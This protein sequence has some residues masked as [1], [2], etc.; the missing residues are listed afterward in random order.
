MNKD[1][2]LE[3][4]R[5]MLEDPKQQS[6]L[7]LIDTG[8][9]DEDIETFLKKSGLCHY[10]KEKLI[11]TSE[12]NPFELLIVGLSYTCDDCGIDNLR[13]QLLV[14]D[15][16]KRDTII[17][18]LFIQIMKHLTMG[19]R[20]VIHIY[21]SND[22]LFL[23]LEDLEKIEGALIHFDETIF[24]IS[25][26]KNNVLQD[27]NIIKIKSLKKV[28]NNGFMGNRLEK[29]HISYK[30]NE[31]YRY[32]LDAIEAGLKKNEIEYSIDR[33]DVM[34][35]DNIDAYE[36]EIGFSD[37][38]IMI[39]IPEYLKSLECM[40]EMT[41]IFEKGNVEER[42]FPIV[43][44]EDIFRNSSGLATIKEYWIHEK[45]KRIAQLSVN[46]GKSS[47]WRTELDK[48]E[49]ILYRLDE[50]WG[51]INRHSTGNFKELIENDAAL[52]MTELNKG[53]SK[54][55]AHF[56]EK[57]IPSDDTK[58]IISRKVNQN[59]EKSI[60]IENNTGSIT[61]S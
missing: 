25:K 31:K 17:Y 13:N 10:V 9:N 22:L 42:L 11:Q 3:Q 32:V 15:G 18:S 27:G 20:T 35:R 5:R 24:V 54:A 1:Y 37:K 8:L 38:V 4:L 2:E 23:R 44:L 28:F 36:K 51:F 34:Y 39:V 45:N 30:N 50:F 40:F 7:Y 43:D 26:L 57:F 6:G 48:I 55:A 58:P 47:F 49:D 19:E 61:I 53:F 56:D 52:L 41:Q 29:V 16:R 12:G 60:Y 14:A 59:G 33:K 46:S 21:G